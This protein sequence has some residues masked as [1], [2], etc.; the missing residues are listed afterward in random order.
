MKS[1]NQTYHINASPKKVWQALVDPKIIHKWGGGEAKMDDKV[2]YRFSLWGSEIFGKNIEVDPEKKLVQEWYGGRWDKPSIVTF[3]LEKDSTGTVLELNHEEI[4][5]NELD[6]VDEGWKK[7]YLGPL[8][9]LLEKS[10]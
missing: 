7:F 9:D 2:G 5:D 10:K 8:K 6:D 3:T 1:L 4:P